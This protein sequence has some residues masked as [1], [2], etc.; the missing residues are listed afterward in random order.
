VDHRRA[1]GGPGRPP[2]S[3]PLDLICFWESPIAAAAHLGERENI[4]DTSE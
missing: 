3:N 4:K 2:N 1:S